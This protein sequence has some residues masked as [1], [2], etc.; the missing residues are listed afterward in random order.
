MTTSRQ[1]TAGGQSACRKSPRDLPLPAR[2]GRWRWH[3]RRTRMA[4][5]PYLRLP[6]TPT[7]AEAPWTSTEYIPF[8]RLL[9][10]I[11]RT[12]CSLI[13]ALTTGVPALTTHLIPRAPLGFRQSSLNHHERIEVPPTPSLRPGPIPGNVNHANALIS[14]LCDIFPGHRCS[15]TI[16][17]PT[18]APSSPRF[19]STYGGL[20]TSCSGQLAPSS[21]LS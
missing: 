15:S 1:G 5:A 2:H 18:R 10:S 17:W 9:C 13:T 12:S 8:F 4:C 11:P 20:P 21:R 6:A 14:V 3:W 19:S 7:T 16:T